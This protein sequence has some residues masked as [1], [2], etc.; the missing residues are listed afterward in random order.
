MN[1]TILIKS[2]A[3]SQAPFLAY[4]IG[5]K[6]AE[7]HSLK[8]IFFLQ[9]GVSCASCLDLP[10][11]EP[12]IGKLF[13]EFAKKNQIELLVC[14]TAASRR[15]LNRLEQG[16]SLSGLTEINVANFTNDRTLIF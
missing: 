6:L 2:K 12:N 8:Q 1:Y 15:G 16:F 5:L 11:D 9:D 10:V 3:T 4:Q 13:S 14:S 7:K